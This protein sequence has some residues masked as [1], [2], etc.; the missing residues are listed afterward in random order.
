MNST[1]RLVATS[2]AAVIAVAP[3]APTLSAQAV[4]ALAN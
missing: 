3:G 2:T 4:I 1:S